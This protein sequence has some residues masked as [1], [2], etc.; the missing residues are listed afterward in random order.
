MGT[1]SR[2]P[3]G[4]MTKRVVAD[5]SAWVLQPKYKARP[6]LPNRSLGPKTGR[7]V[8]PYHFLQPPTARVNGQVP[9]HDMNGGRDMADVDLRFD[10]IQGAP[11]EWLKLKTAN[12]VGTIHWLG[13][14]LVLTNVA[15]E[16]YGGDGNGF[17]DFDFRVPHE[18]ADYDF[19]VNVTN[20]D[21]HELA[22]D[23]SSPTNLLEG[24][25]A[26]TLV[27]IHADSRDW[28]M[29]NGFGHAN[30]HDGLLWDI[31]IF[32]ILS[33]VLNTILPGM[34]NSRATDAA[35]RFVITNGVFYTDSL[36]IRSTMT[37]LEYTGTAIRWGQARL[38]Y[39]SILMVLIGGMVGTIMVAMYLPI[40]SMAGKI[41][42]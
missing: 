10:I 32:G 14:T 15:A 37:R 8:E 20:A 23:L 36:E 35:A 11:F 42:G 9:L 18:G 19:T 17:A 27:V 1:Y 25:L 7:L 4:K 16:F 29:W 6:A 12:V 28:Q 39:G 34:G 30:V 33:P 5:L 41:K 13:Q 24:T 2:R 38:T 3:F 21:L 22:G 40:F 26:G 31:P